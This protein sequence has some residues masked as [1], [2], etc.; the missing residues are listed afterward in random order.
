MDNTAQSKSEA[1]E[2]YITGK[3]YFCDL[4]FKVTEDVLIPRIETEKL[5]DIVVEY[6]KTNKIENNKDLKILDIGTGSGCIAISIAKKLPNIKIDAIDISPKAL[7][8]AKE[9]AITNGVGERINF[10]E[11][12]LIENI[13][14][15][16]NI[17]VSNL[18][19]IPTSRIP[20]L[21]NSVK[22]FEP[23]LALDGGEDGFE[24]YRKLFKQIIDN[25]INPDFIAIEF[26]DDHN[27]LS[28]KEAEKYF[29][30]H[31]IKVEK[32][33]FNYDR[34]LTIQS[35]KNIQNK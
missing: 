12:N 10:I 6:I 9:N 32:D 2:E 1:P 22:N 11:N 20:I 5:V 24:L 8:V 19:Y 13:N 33:L 34:F 16:Y 3:A 21:E 27:E 28:I 25:K 4:E 30:N 7:V 29:T 35:I 14:I 26:D 15:H 17:I 23:T 18:P 31:K